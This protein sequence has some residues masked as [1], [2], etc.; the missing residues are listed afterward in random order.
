MQRGVAAA[1]SLR[2]RV[3]VR[4]YSWLLPELS[5]P[6][7]LSRQVS[8]QPFRVALRGQLLRAHHWLASASMRWLQVAPMRARGWPV[9][10]RWRVQPVPLRRRLVV[11][12]QARAAQQ[13]R[14]A[15]VFVSV[16]QRNRQLCKQAST[17]KPRACNS[18]QPLSGHSRGITHETRNWMQLL[19]RRL[20]C[21]DLFLSDASLRRV[22]ADV[23]TSNQQQST[24]RRVNFFMLA[25][26]L[27]EQKVAR[28]VV[29][30]GV[31][32][33]TLED[34]AF[35]FKH[36]CVGRNTRVGIQFP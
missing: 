27:R 2:R 6:L 10:R 21:L 23:F 5:Q 7:A 34:H 18:W 22:S 36:V 32:Q 30:T 24:M 20:L 26:G 12:R 15:A 13:R 4:F 17:T 35:F 33:V 11:S 14:Q 9:L 19:S 29:C 25:A 1:F 8:Q 16:R 31:L 28:G 3:S